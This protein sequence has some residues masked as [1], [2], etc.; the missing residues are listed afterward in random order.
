MFRLIT[1]FALIGSPSLAESYVSDGFGIVPAEALS[2][3][4]AAWAGLRI[5][6]KADVVPAGEPASILLFVGPKALVA[7]KDEGHAVALVF[8]AQGNLCL[9]YTSPSPRDS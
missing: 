8:D 1:L 3:E 5:G 6:D 7:G 9:L 4:R 2:D